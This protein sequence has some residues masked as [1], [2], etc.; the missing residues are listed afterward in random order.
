[1]S[2]WIFLHYLID[3][4]FLRYCELNCTSKGFSCNF[5]HLAV[6][7]SPQVISCNIFDKCSQPEYA[8]IDMICM[9]DFPSNISITVKLGVMN[10]W[11]LRIS[12]SKDFLV[13]QKV[14]LIVL[15]KN[16]RLPSKDSVK[17]D[18]RVAHYRRIPFLNFSIWSTLNDPL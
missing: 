11:F 4:L 8:G 18:S 2:L 16:K 14:S 1:M 5:L 13:S 6:K 3:M 12:S 10:S 7:Q 15:L 17:E 9:P